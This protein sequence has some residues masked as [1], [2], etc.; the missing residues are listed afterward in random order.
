M[1][2]CLEEIMKRSILIILLLCIVSFPSLAKV[3]GVKGLQWIDPYGRQPAKYSLWNREYCVKDRETKIG[4]VYEKGI[5]GRQNLVDVIVNK[6]I[7][8]DIATEIDTFVNDLLIAGYSVQIDTIAGMSHITLRDHLAGIID[9]V[10]AVFVGELPVAWFETYGFG[11]WEEFPHDVYFCDLDGAYID[12]DL[13]GIYDNHTGSVEPEIWVGRIY[14]R[15][16]TWDNEIRLLKNYFYKNHQYRTYGSSLPERGL[17]FVDDDWS[18]WYDCYLN[19]VY[20]NVVVV[21]DDYQTTAANYRSQLAQGYEWVHLCAHSS[22][23]GHT[24]LYGYSG[25][26]GTVF[27]YEI[28]TLEPDALF[29]NLFACSGTRFVEENY[30]A[31]WYLF[32]EPYGLLAIGSTKTGSM[33]FFDDFYGPLGQQNMCVGEAF[34]YWF[35]LWGESDW[36]WF[37]GLNILGDPT[38]KPKSQVAVRKSSSQEKEKRMS[39]RVP[40]TCSAY[41]KQSQGSIK[42]TNFLTN[43]EPPEIVGS[44]P[45]SDGFSKITTSEDDKVWV[46]WESGRSV[47]NGRSDI[48]SSYRNGSSWSNAMVVGPVYYWDFYPDIGFDNL[49]RPVAVWAGWYESFGNYQYDIFYSIY[50]SSWSTRQMLHPL[51][52]GF[53]LKP[54]LIRDNSNILWVAWESRRDVNLNIYTSHFNGSSWSSQQ[55]VTTDSADETTPSM[56]VDSLGRVWV[57]YCRRNEWR[58]EVWGHYYTGSQWLESGPISGS[59]KHAYRPSASV[60]GD[61]NIWVAWHSTDNGNPDIYGSY[62]NGSNWSVPIQITVSSESDLFP[63]LTTDNNGNVWLVYQSKTGGDWNIY[64]SYCIDSVWITPSL[65][66]NLSGADINPQITCSNSNELWISWQSYSTNNW[67]VMVSHRSGLDIDEVKDE[68]TVLNFSVTPM[69]FS[70]RVRITTQRPDQKIKIYDIKGSLIQTL[71]SNQ[72]RLAFW[73]PQNIPPGIYFVVLADKKQF[74]SKKVILFN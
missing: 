20:S 22:P 59:H 26:R 62:Y 16:L 7:Y 61:G 30:S 53:D 56:S 11:S 60:D 64:Y 25:F 44:D 37:Y 21:N 2:E 67:E 8:P 55:Q 50:S 5:K 3:T 74:T 72:E 46:I 18:Y 32:V 70:K 10:G 6:S 24:F 71:F 17:S 49:N 36:D 12:A 31:G 69:L 39:L 1:A 27:N 68:L 13:D 15:N 43:W 51:D 47:S 35:T 33:L 65:V 4:M 23:W 63:D 29:Y 54:T 42:P 19:L 45:E 34:K 28:F 41:A 14:A 38:L 52:P 58:A 57:F 73:S 9:L 48:Y 66:T 40:L